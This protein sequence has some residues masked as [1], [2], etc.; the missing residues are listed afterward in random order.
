MSIENIERLNHSLRDRIN[1]K[2]IG[3]ALIAFGLSYS[4]TDLW[5]EVIGV[6]LPEV[7]W[8]YSGMIAAA[9]GY[10]IISFSSRLATECIRT[11][12]TN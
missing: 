7:I 6:Q 11:F 3:Y 2:Y 8:A 10:G 5:G 1:M 12:L 4:G 9:I